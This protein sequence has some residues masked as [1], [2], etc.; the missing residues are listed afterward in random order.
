MNILHLNLVFY[1][2]GVQI[3]IQLKHGGHY[4][5]I[6][7]EKFYFQIFFCFSNIMSNF[8]HICIKILVL[9]KLSIL[10][11]F[12]SFVYRYSYMHMFE[13]FPLTAV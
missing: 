9:I 4:S 2:I 3:Y 13:V 1:S 10:C 6:R 11:T 5:F 8:N 7:T 12:E